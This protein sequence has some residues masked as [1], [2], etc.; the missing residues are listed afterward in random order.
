MKQS[1]HSV[2]AFSAS[3][4]WINCP[5][6]MA[7]PENTAEGVDAG[8]YAD[9][10]TAAHTLASWVLKDKRKRCDDF[11]GTKI[12]AGKREFEVTEEFA[13]HVQTYV[14]DVQRRAIGGY[15]MVEQRVT[16]E[17]VEGF[18]ASNYGTSDAIIA[19][20]NANGLVDQTYGVVEDL[21]FGQGE[22]VYAWE[23]AHGNE[24]FTMMTY[25]EEDGVQIERKVV[26]NYQLMM[27]ALACLADIRLLID[28]PSHILIVINQPRLGHVS[29]LRVPIK[30]L[31]RFALFAADALKIA[32]NAMGLYPDDPKLENWLNPGEKQC[33]WCRAPTE[34]P[35]RCQAREKRVQKEISADFDVIGGEPPV[36]PSNP[37]TVARALL[38]VP[39]VTDWCRAVVAQANELVGAGVKLMGPDAQPYKFV[40]GRQ[41]DRKWADEKQAESALLGVLGPQAYQPQKI[42]TASGASKILDKKKTANMWKDVFVPLIKRAPGKPLLVMGSDPRPA[43]SPA[44]GS[45]EFDEISSNE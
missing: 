35:R 44:A 39:F 27:Y 29:E 30:V 42:L 32:T 31:E 3:V 24:P 4:R 33:R 10:G 19:I 9:E 25:A 5:G 11:V 26:P 12:Q 17:G 41:G 40:E 6:S 28:D 8:V 36:V 22:K 38:A 23:L 43:F 18:D 20:P 7:F 21:K 13:S 34:G 14:D 45:D 2:F 1:D 15:L 37:P 16:L